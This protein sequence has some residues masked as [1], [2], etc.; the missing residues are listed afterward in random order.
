VRTSQSVTLPPLA[1]FFT[2]FRDDNDCLDY[3]WRSRFSPD[4][5]SALCPECGEIREFRAEVDTTRLLRWG[6]ASCGC[7]LSPVAGTI[8]QKSRIPIH[9]YFDAI[10]VL[11]EPGRPIHV[12]ELAYE[13][14]ITFATAAEV[15]RVLDGRL[16]TSDSSA[17]RFAFELLAGEELL[18]SH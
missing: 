6:C 11:R 16:D 14:G 2:L 13:V 9:V 8:F 12:E 3:L 10:G 18:S 15:I 17:P 7:F 4:G 1:S 5:S